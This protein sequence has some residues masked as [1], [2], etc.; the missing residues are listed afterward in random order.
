MEKRI[1]VYGLR[2]FDQGEITDVMPAQVVRSDET[3]SSVTMHMM[4][5]T[6]DQIREQL[7][8]S[9]DAFFEL[10]E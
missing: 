9:L 10:H 8:R 7:L 3:M 2:L 1:L 5:G 4:D 6:K